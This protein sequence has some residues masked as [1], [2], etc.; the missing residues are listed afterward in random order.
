MATTVKLPSGNVGLELPGSR[1][2]VDP[3]FVTL[4]NVVA[5]G[6]EQYAAAIAWVESEREKRAEAVRVRE[7]EQAEMRKTIA[8]DVERQHAAREAL[9]EAEPWRRDQL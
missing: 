6:D 7:E 5:Y 3:C 2:V 4:R 8:A 9:L 1:E